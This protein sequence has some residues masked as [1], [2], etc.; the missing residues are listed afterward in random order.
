M[1]LYV[2]TIILQGYQQDINPPYGYPNNNNPGVNNNNGYPN[3]NANGNN[4]FQSLPPNMQLMGPPGPQF[5][6]NPASSSSP[7]PAFGFASINLGQ[8]N[9]RAAANTAGTR[10]DWFLVRRTKG[11]NGAPN[12]NY[13]GRPMLVS[14][15]GQCAV[16]GGRHS[17]N[18]NFFWRHN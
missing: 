12:D 18:R 4:N 11:Q 7:S 8:P 3:G 9:S 5:Q 6:Q 13:D 16:V 15:N 14:L 10:E 2:F 1:R 17:L